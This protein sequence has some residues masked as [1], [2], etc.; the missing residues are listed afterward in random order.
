MPFRYADM[1]TENFSFNIFRSIYISVIKYIGEFHLS[2][3]RLFPLRHPSERTRVNPCDGHGDQKSLWKH[4]PKW[5]P[6]CFFC[7]SWCIDFFPRKKVAKKIRAAFA[8]RQNVQ[9]LTLAKIHPIWSP[10]WRNVGS[11]SS[12]NNPEILERS[13]PI[14]GP[15]H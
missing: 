14:F 5:S 12:K 4:W 2:E 11:R 10:W 7:K 6:N 3:G 8:I 13:R 1:L 9:K 15:R